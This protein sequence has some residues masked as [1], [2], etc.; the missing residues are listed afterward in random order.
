MDKYSKVTFHN[1]HQMPVIGLG[2]WQL[3]PNTAATVENALDI[4]YRLIDT[5]S[6]YGSQPGIG[7]ALTKTSVPREE[8]FLETK[9]EEDDDAYQAVQ[10]YLAEMDQD[11]ADLIVIHR[12]PPS[13]AGVELWE[14]LIKAKQAG[15]T[16][17]IGVSNY[18]AVLIDELIKATGEVPVLNQ[19]EW[20]PFGHSMEHFNYCQ[21][22]GIFIQAY[23]PLT[24]AKRLDD[25]TLHELADQHQKSPAQILL[26]WNL[27]LG[28]VPIPRA[29]QKDH[30]AENL[31]I[32]DFKLSADEMKTLHELN[33][34]YS[35]LG[36]LQYL[37]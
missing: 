18:S 23:S 19:I 34:H 27:Q 14:G 36:S 10:D 1:G 32:F 37:A 33:E 13:G 26:R 12:P 25:E 3:S 8:I 29:N 6:D 7:E 9:V 20:S 11:Y 22:H 31:D 17:D 24:R 16:I 28:T 35:S 30:Q 15:L 2:T 21:E 5:S 4:G